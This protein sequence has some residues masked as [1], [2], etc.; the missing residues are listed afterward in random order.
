ML[1]EAVT[2]S[3]F[4]TTMTLLN[5][6]KP[7]PSVERYK[8]EIRKVGKQKDNLAKKISQARATATHQSVPENI[9]TED[10]VRNIQVANHNRR[11]LSKWAL[12]PAAWKEMSPE[13]QK[14]WCDMKDAARIRESRSGTPLLKDDGQQKKQYSNPSSAN[15]QHPSQSTRWSNQSQRHAQF[16]AQE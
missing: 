10:H 16:T 13:Q 1:R 5:L 8:A 6:T 3:A 4:E 2:D 14:L 15:T 7:P 12:S 9:P 11:H